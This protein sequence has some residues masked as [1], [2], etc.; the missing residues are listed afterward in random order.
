MTAFY[1]VAALELGLDGTLLYAAVAR[2]EAF[3]AGWCPPRKFYAGSTSP[4]LGR[5]SVA[6]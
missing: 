5:I 6:S 1:V 2:R 4:M 3:R